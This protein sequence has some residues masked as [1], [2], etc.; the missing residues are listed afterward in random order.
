MSSS[1]S[2]KMPFEKQTWHCP[3]Q[4]RRYLPLHLHLH[5]YRHP[6]TILVAKEQASRTTHPA[7]MNNMP[8]TRSP[9][10]RAFSTMPKTHFQQQPPPSPVP[11]HHQE[12][13]EPSEAGC[14]PRKKQR[15]EEEGPPRLAPVNKPQIPSMVDAGPT[16]PRVALPRAS[17]SPALRQRDPKCKGV[18]V[19]PDK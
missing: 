3:H 7:G 12:T 2:W 13:S 5:Q 11:P 1:T 4:L 17:P 18:S 14:P 15:R 16:S 6:T 8:C 9:G 19:I 10:T